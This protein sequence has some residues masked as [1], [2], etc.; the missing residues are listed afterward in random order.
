MTVTK[1]HAGVGCWEHQ[2]WWIK[3]LG[4][5]GRSAQA[6]EQL[7]LWEFQAS[8]DYIIRH[9]KK[10]KP[11]HTPQTDQWPHDMVRHLLGGDRNGVFRRQAGRLTAR[12]WPPPWTPCRAMSIWTCQTWPEECLKKTG[13]T[14][15][16]VTWMAFDFICMYKYASTCVYVEAGGQRQVSFIPRGTVH[17]FLKTGSHYLDFTSDPLASVS[18]VQ[19]SFLIWALGKD[20]ESHNNK[21]ETEKSQHWT[22]TSRKLVR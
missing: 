10:Q 13:E 14:F 3:H 12:G 8:H 15:L 1:A 11:T 9:R 22:S 5:R 7:G 21:E 19:V 20:L 17:L 4:G 6:G 2:E 16:Y 18:Q